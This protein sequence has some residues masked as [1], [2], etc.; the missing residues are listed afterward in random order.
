MLLSEGDRDPVLLFVSMDS[1]EQILIKAG[2]LSV[3]KPAFPLVR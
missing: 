1:P 2:L 3:C